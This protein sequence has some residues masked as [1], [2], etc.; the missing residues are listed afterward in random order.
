[1][2]ENKHNIG[3]EALVAVLAICGT[4]IAGMGLRAYEVSRSK[5]VNRKRK[6]IYDFKKKKWIYIDDTTNDNRE[7]NNNEGA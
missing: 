1:M 7:N 4:A 2:N 5:F 6:M 3:T